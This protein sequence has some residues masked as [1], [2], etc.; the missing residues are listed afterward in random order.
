MLLHVSRL[1]LVQP[2]YHAGEDTCGPKLTFE[3]ERP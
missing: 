2:D 3:D 1:E